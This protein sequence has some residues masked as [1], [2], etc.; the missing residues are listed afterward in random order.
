MKAII[1]KEVIYRP[2]H[3]QHG[4]EL[5]SVV[6]LEVYLASQGKTREDAIDSFERA[7]VATHLLTEEAKSTPD[8]N[9]ITPFT[10]DFKAPQ[11]YWNEYEVLKKAGN[12]D[13]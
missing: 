11:E 2:D 10:R 8:K 12:T 7:W 9:I 5:W 6:G 3:Q 1:H 4:E 13:I